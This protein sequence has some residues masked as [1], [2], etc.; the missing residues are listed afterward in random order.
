M[1]Y[2]I[3]TGAALEKAFEKDIKSVWSKSVV[4]WL[5]DRGELRKL[6]TF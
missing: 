2:I 3:R 6:D 5:M 4:T 1:H